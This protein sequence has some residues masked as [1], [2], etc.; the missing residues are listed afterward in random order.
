[1]YF[2]TSDLYVLDTDHTNYAIVYSCR[3]LY[4]VEPFKL[5]WVLTRKPVITEEER[6][7]YYQRAEILFQKIN[8]KMSDLKPIVQDCDE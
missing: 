7:I 2:I 4:F 8:V 3:S 6:A 5:A 1:M